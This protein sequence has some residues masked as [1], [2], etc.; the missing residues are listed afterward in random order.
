T[1]TISSLN[2]AKE[3]AEEKKAYYEGKEFMNTE[4]NVALI[5]SGISKALDA[6]IAAG[7]I[8]SGGLKLIPAFL[9]G[10]AGFGG[11]PT[12]S[13]TIGG[14]QIGNSAEMA[15]QT[16]RAIATALDKEAA[17]TSTVGSYKR[18]KEEWDFQGRLATIEAD[19][20]QFQINAAEIRQAIA[21]RELENHEMQIENAK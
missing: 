5:L 20:I 1:E 19:Q 4:E 15:V 16:I 3:N 12:V 14:Q 18:R 2:K 7:Y 21:E 13:A 8:I 17:F 11:T 9:A 10:G 6:S